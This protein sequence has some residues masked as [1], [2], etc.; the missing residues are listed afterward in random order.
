M[1]QKTT[2]SSLTKP[3][4]PTKLRRTSSIVSLNKPCASCCS[5]E[6]KESALSFHL[7]VH[8]MRCP[9]ASQAPPFWSEDC[10]LREHANW[11]GS[12]TRQT[13]LNVPVIM[14]AFSPDDFNSAASTRRMTHTQE[15]AATQPR[16]SAKL[17]LFDQ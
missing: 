6:R 7:L 15:I 16:Q 10:S 14:R 13:G 3:T 8:S 2:L 1:G 4:R 9:S 17:F 12:A 5:N 11:K